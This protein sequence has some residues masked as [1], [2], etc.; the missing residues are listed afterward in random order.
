MIRVCHFVSV[1]VVENK[2]QMF[3]LRVVRLGK[4]IHVLQD[5]RVAQGSIV[6]DLMTGVVGPDHSI[7]GDVRVSLGIM[8]ETFHHS[9]GV[10]LRLWQSVSSSQIHSVYDAV[11]P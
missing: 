10:V 2:V 3:K 5:L 11:V 9:D 6:D 8:L 7:I 1:H 4:L